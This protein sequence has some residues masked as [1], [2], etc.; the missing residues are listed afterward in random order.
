MSHLKLLNAIKLMG[1]LKNFTRV[2]IKGENWTEGR[3][4]FDVWS[5][6]LSFGCQAVV[7]TTVLSNKIDLRDQ[8]WAD[9]MDFFLVYKIN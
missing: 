9:E 7:S 3:V 4:A 1:F 2:S 6:E 5:S 8:S